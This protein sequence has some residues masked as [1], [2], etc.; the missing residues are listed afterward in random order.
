MVSELNGSLT[1]VHESQRFVTTERVAFERASEAIM[2]GI[3]GNEKAAE[4]MK[5]AV[6]QQ[7]AD[8]D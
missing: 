4:A 2:S 8:A 5:I 6:A 3:K 1:V 7:A